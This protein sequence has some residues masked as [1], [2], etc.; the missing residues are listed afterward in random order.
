[1][2][3]SSGEGEARVTDAE[4]KTF[5]AEQVK[6]EVER[7]FIPMLENLTQFVKETR[8]HEKR[9]DRQV[10]QMLLM[11]AE[12][13]RADGIDPAASEIDPNYRN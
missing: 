8:E 4:L 9:V 6:Q 2:G 1:M 12:M 11:V 10:N 3:H 13:L 7:R 5:I